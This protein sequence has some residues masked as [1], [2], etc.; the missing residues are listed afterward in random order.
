[1][2]L[3]P[4]TRNAP[5]TSLQP[6]SGSSLNVTWNVKSLPLWS[7]GTFENLAVSGA[8]TGSAGGPAMVADGLLLSSTGLSSFEQMAP[9]VPQARLP[10]SVTVTASSPSGSTVISQRS[11]RPSTRLAYVTSPFVTVN[12]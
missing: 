10:D 1:M 11:L 5:L 9:W 12:A 7:S 3:P 6:M 2:T 4:L 8:P